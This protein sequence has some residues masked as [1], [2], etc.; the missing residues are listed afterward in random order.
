MV[1]SINPQDSTRKYKQVVRRK[2][3]S[4][5]NE[6]FFKNTAGISA[7]PLASFFLKN[8][9]SYTTPPTPQFLLSKQRFYI[10]GF[11][12]LLQIKKYTYPT[13]YAT[14]THLPVN[15]D[16]RTGRTSLLKLL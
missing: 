9:C 14:Y 12:L 4:I 16:Y 5:I 1:T 10:Y 13:Y 2:P 15:Y 3:K 11:W 8:L 7:S 6:N